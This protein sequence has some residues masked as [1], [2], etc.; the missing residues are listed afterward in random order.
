MKRGSRVLNLSY[1]IALSGIL[2][3]STINA[4]SN[5][6]E[7][8]SQLEQKAEESS[9]PVKEGFYEYK[10]D[11][12]GTPDIKD[13]AEATLHI[14][15]T[16]IE[17]LEK[18]LK[19]AEISLPETSLYHLIFTTVSKNAK[20]WGIN[21]NLKLESYV[22]MTDKGVKPF[23][24]MRK[25]NTTMPGPDTYSNREIFFD[26]D[27]K[28]LTINDYSKPDKKG[29]KKK[30]TKV[31]EMPKN[32]TEPLSILVNATRIDKEGNYNFGYVYGNKLG[33]LEVKVSK[34]KEGF[35]AK[36]TM[37]ENILAKGSRKIKLYYESENDTSKITNLDVY[38]PIFLIL[39]GWAEG[40]L[41]GEEITSY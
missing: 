10:I 35:L 12:V 39:N 30:K 3:Y 16:T 20:S 29:V 18:V 22:V 37:P 27:N 26:Y 19:G 36:F 40:K 28:K 9:L 4:F 13:A 41:I 23:L 17:E 6:S 7:I 11:F 25:E 24:F 32:M 1:R 31:F 38:I 15:K 5:N 14:K 34:E 33:K 21:Q 8:K 2:L